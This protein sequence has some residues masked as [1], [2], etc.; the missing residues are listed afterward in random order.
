LAHAVGRLYN[1]FAMYIT[2]FVP[3]GMMLILKRYFRMMKYLP[4]VLFTN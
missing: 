2:Q 1:G 3:N 4:L